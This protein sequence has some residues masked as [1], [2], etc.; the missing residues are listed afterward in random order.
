MV[1]RAARMLKSQIRFL[2]PGLEHKLSED[3]ALLVSCRLRR[4]IP[5]NQ[6]DPLPSL[7]ARG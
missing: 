7:K 3:N 5:P 4:A 6:D 2:V 1:S